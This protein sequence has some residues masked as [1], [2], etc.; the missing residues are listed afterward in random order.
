MHKS[1]IL[2]AFLRMD[3]GHSPW[4]DA[5]YGLVLRRLR[6]MRLRVQYVGPE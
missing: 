6:T 2:R 1:A 5:R 3:E 4:S